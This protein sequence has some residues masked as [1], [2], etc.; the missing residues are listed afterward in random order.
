VIASAELHQ[1]IGWQHYLRAIQ[2]MNEGK[3]TENAALLHR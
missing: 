2:E 3:A 1:R